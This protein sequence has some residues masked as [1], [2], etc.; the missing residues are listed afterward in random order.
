[1]SQLAHEVYGHVLVPMSDD[2]FDKQD[3]PR[4]GAFPL[5]PY[6]GRL[7]RAELVTEDQLFQLRGNPYRNGDAMHGP[8]QRRPW[9]IANHSASVLSMSLEYEADEDWP[10]SFRA[11][12]HFSI[13]DQRLDVTLSLLNRSARPSP[14]G[15]GWHPYFAVG[16][17]VELFCD[18]HESWSLP[19][20][21]SKD[22]P[23]LTLLQS[24]SFGIDPQAKH[25]SKWSRAS[26]AIP[27]G[28]VSLLRT[29]A[30]EYL[31]LHRTE[32]YLCLEPVSHLSGALS[33]PSHLRTSAGIMELAP[34]EMMVGGV[35]ICVGRQPSSNNINE[36][37]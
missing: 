13:S 28:C 20:P 25:L 30:L 11:V 29:S 16:S 8:A 7:K 26:F 9:T 24:A 36:F 12:Q 21:G 31:V 18:A 4:A 27:T 17:G 19:T 32:A 34:G 22:D 3:W 15:M 23:T 10:Y 35:S 33:L 2:P 6:H 14:A 37:Q 1:M 5:F